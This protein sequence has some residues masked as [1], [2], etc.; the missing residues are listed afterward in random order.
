MSRP[1]AVVMSSV[2]LFL[3]AANL[4]EVAAGVRIAF[5]AGSERRRGARGHPPA[6]LDDDDLGAKPGEPQRAERHGD[7]LAEIEHA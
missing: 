2:Q 4:I 5:D 3:R 7:E 1:A 6:Q